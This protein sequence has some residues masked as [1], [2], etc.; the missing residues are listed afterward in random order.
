MV[1]EPSGRE[2]GG[3]D[4]LQARR[5]RHRHHLAARHRPRTDDQARS[6][7]KPLLADEHRPAAR[8][9][10]AD[11]RRRQASATPAS[12]RS[13]SSTA[14]GSG[15]RSHSPHHQAPSTCACKPAR[16]SPESRSAST[17]TAASS[18]PRKAGAPSKLVDQQTGLPLIWTIA[19]A[20]VEEDK[21]LI[22]N[23]LPNLF[24]LWPDCPLEIIIGDGVLDNAWVCG[25]LEAR[26][27]IHPMF[28]RRTSKRRYRRRPRRRSRTRPSMAS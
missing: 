24:R 1:A 20:N 25:E 7:P 15:H 9:R 13:P 28:T 5:H 23:L 10:N 16:R 4:L 2:P 18:T 22:R 14:H 6:R 19:P 8:A 26:W 17:T 27:S 12:A 3:M 11:R 21:V